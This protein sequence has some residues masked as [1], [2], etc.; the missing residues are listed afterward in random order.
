MCDFVIIGIF[1]MCLLVD[2]VE[3]VKSTLWDKG[4]RIMLKR[5]KIVKYVLKWEV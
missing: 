3:E 5:Y 4:I 1:L 2:D